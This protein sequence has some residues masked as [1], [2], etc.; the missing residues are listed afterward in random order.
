MTFEGLR[1]PLDRRGPTPRSG[2]RRVPAVR[3]DPR[4]PHAARVVRRRGAAR[5]LDLARPRRQPVGLVGRPRRRA[6]GST[7]GVAVG[8]HLDSVPDG[9]AFDGPLGVVSALAAVD[10]LRAPG[11][12]PAESVGGGLLR[13]RGGRPVRHRLCRIAAASPARSTADRARGLT[14]A[15]GTTMAE[16]IA[17]GRPRPGEPRPRRRDAAPGSARF[18]E[19]HV[20]QGRGA[21]DRRYDQA[22]RGRRQRHLA[23][24]PL[25]D[26]LPG[27]G[28]PRRHDPRSTDRDDAMLEL[29]RPR[30]RR[31]GGRRR[32]TA[33]S[34]RSARSRVEPGGVNAIASAV[35]AWLD[36]RGADEAACARSWP[37]SRCG[38]TARRHGHRG[39]L[40]PDHPVR[41]R[42]GARLADRAR[43]DT[44]VARHRRRP[45][46]GNPCRRRASR[47]RCCSSAT[48][49]ASRTRRP[50]TP[51]RPTATPASPPSPRCSTDLAEAAP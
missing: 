49:P 37:T 50:S 45:R 40:D 47:R 46:R 21:R 41:P 1:R 4:G 42:P 35:T 31:P 19:L 10:A 20:E 18:V 24:R 39:V 14:D 6:D 32:G 8:S 23:A 43:P 2:D 11:F 15:D 28:Q 44:P 25:A 7:G 33:A 34:R 29:R 30:P 26:R 13:R 5:G 9:G 12:A 48:R 51:T 3:L 22:P 16:A 17:R 27:R 38:R 36:A